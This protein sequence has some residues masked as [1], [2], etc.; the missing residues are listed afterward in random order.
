M[1]GPYMDYQTLKLKQKNLSACVTKLDTPSHLMIF[2]H[3]AGAGYDHRHMRALADTLA[4]INI[5]TLRF[6]FPFM[7]AGSRRVDSKTD[8]IVTLDAAISTANELMPGIP[9][10]LGGHSFGGRMATHY[11]AE[12]RDKNIRGVVLFSFPLHVSKKPAVIRAAHLPEVQTPMLFISGDRDTLADKALL[13][14][15]I[16]PLPAGRT[17]LHWLETADHSYKILKRT[18]QSTKDIYVEVSEVTADWVRSL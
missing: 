9:L 13:E 1:L 8:C 18:R 3:G 15:V 4:T 11:L 10:L 5:A 14:S 17:T 16:K 6:N 2:A 7:E 12:H